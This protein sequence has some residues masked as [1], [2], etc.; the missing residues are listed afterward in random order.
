[1]SK[2]KCR[3]PRLLH[4]I[5]NV[6]L[7][8]ETKITNSMDFFSFVKTE[9]RYSEVLFCIT[10]LLGALA[11]CFSNAFTKI[12]FI[13]G[14]VATIFYHFYNIWVEHKKEEEEENIMRFNF[15]SDGFEYISDLSD[16]L[17]IDEIVVTDT[18]D[19]L[20][21]L[22]EYVNHPE[23]FTNKDFLPENKVMIVGDTGTGKNTLIRAFA[24]ETSLP[25]LRV[26]ASRFF[27]VEDII[28]SLFKPAP[29][30]KYII[31][32]D[33]YDLLTDSDNSPVD[34]PTDV[35][36]DKLR[37]Y[38]DA[39]PE[40]IVLATCESSTFV[41]PPTTQRIFKKVIFCD[42]PDI[43]Q[44]TKLLQIFTT[45][46]TLEE[47]ID[48]VNISKTCIGF[49]I[50]EIKYLVQI[51]L[52]LA[53]KEKREKVSQEDF[54]NAFDVMSYGVSSKKHSKEMQRIVAYHE[55]GHALVQYLL[56]GEDSVL[57]VISAT[58]GDAGGYTMPDIDEDSVVMTEQELINN[59]CMSYGGRCAELIE[60]GKL[61]TG[62]V[63]DIASA[64]SVISNMI[65]RYGMSPAIG[66]I[67]VAP[68][69]VM[70]STI[71]ES[72]YMLNLI[73]EESMRIAHECEEKTLT[74]LKAHKRELDILANYLIEHESLDGSEM[75]KLFEN[76][77]DD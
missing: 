53:R 50:G 48:L 24:K 59:I 52:S 14:V 56:S 62:A 75:K 20:R 44:R 57:R 76:V 63:S 38:L 25:I 54:F 70:V 22:I 18:A 29:F 16:A 33:N 28:E 30:M 36:I 5:Q 13:I 68:K 43:D 4:S 8:L 67:N 9:N 41:A 37:T 69:V 51:A 42:D 31:Q 2:K 72:E 47:N 40:I 10:L 26:H 27:D 15:L 74:L 17:S 6:L 12:L 65:Q 35:F 1:M 55:A 58:R 3:Q 7:S 60:F 32:I 73:S 77:K 11:I 61:S 34:V 19:E 46:L 39:Y 66:P 21:E 23:K 71:N 64:T 45:N 49:T